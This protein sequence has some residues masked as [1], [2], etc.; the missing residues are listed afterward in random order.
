MDNLNIAMHV[1]VLVFLVVL[2]LVAYWEHRTCIRR[3]LNEEIV[4]VT[5]LAEAHGMHSDIL[6]DLHIGVREVSSMFEAADTDQSGYCELSEILQWLDKELHLG[7]EVCN[8]I[9]DFLQEVFPDIFQRG[10]TPR[11]F[12]SVLKKIF[13]CIVIPH[14]DQ[15]ARDH[16]ARI[17]AESDAKSAIEGQRAG[18]VQ[19]KSKA[20]KVIRHSSQRFKPPKAP[21]AVRAEAAPRD[22]AGADHAESPVEGGVP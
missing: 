18:M 11:T 2:M 16:L 5:H 22:Q 15:E 7:Q 4:R 17:L 8:S 20:D 21:P 14:R 3:I 13:A 9:Q 12:E 6:A 1:W 10:I 19:Q